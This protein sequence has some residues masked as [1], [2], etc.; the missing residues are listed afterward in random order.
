VVII[1]IP[2]VVKR[3]EIIGRMLSRGSEAD[4]TKFGARPLGKVTTPGGDIQ[5]ISIYGSDL[6]GLDC[7]SLDFDVIQET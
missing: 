6:S 4:K 2:I 3:L 7:E 1:P 5:Q